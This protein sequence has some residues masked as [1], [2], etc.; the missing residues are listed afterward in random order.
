M[1]HIQEI[2]TKFIKSLKD[3][4]TKPTQVNADAV[5]ITSYALIKVILDNE[6]TIYKYLTN[7]LNLNEQ[8]YNIFIENIRNTPI[9]ELFTYSLEQNLHVLYLANYMYVI[10]NSENKQYDNIF[11]TIEEYKI[12]ELEIASYLRYHKIHCNPLLLYIFLIYASE[13]LDIELNF[14]E[15]YGHDSPLFDYIIESGIIHNTLEAKQSIN[16]LLMQ[17]VPDGTNFNDVLSGDAL[18]RKDDGIRRTNFDYHG[19]LGTKLYKVPENKILVIITPFNRVSSSIYT[20]LEKNILQQIFKKSNIVK[21]INNYTCY[22]DFVV[23]ADGLKDCVLYG[24]QVYYPGQPYYDINL[25][26]STKDKEDFSFMGT[27]TYTQNMSGSGPELNVEHNKKLVNTSI[28]GLIAGYN[29]DIH[30]Y[31]DDLELIFVTSCRTFNQG[32][33]S[34]YA[35]EMMYRY[36]KIHNLLNDIISQCD[37]QIEPIFMHS[38][39]TT[40]AYEMGDMYRK[41]DESKIKNDAEKLSLMFN[42]RLSPMRK[43]EFLINNSSTPGNK[44]R[45]K[46]NDRILSFLLSA[47]DHEKINRLYG[48]VFQLLNENPSYLS[49]IYDNMKKLL[50][51][52]LEHILTDYKNLLNLLNYIVITHNFNNLYMKLENTA[53]EVYPVSIIFTVYL[54]FIKN[55]DIHNPTINTLVLDTLSYMFNL[56]NIQLKSKMT[57][58]AQLIQKNT[59]SNSMNYKVLYELQ[60]HIY[61]CFD[62]LLTWFNI[63]NNTYGFNLQARQIY[64]LFYNFTTLIWNEYSP[65]FVVISI[66]Q[67]YEKHRNIIDNHMFLNIFN[68]LIIIHEGM[69]TEEKD[70]FILH[71]KIMLLLFNNIYKPTKVNINTY[72]KPNTTQK[73]SAVKRKAS[74]L[75][76]ST[77]NTINTKKSK[78]N[79][80]SIYIFNIFNIVNFV[81]SKFNNSKIDLATIIRK[82]LNYINDVKK[83]D[84]SL[85]TL[86]DKIKTTYIKLVD[87][88]VHGFSEY[89][90]EPITVDINPYQNPI[91]ITETPMYDAATPMDEINTPNQALSPTFSASLQ[92]NY[93]ADTPMPLGEEGEEREEMELN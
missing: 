39:V 27:Y 19:N 83:N 6:A 9:H 57:D 87:S 71:A 16:D 24:M 42:K 21:F 88:I 12:T 15:E 2:A 77:T 49:H 26:V 5:S 37:I 40:C 28:A 86:L 14:R 35:I 59:N 90:P 10:N 51:L 61:D 78:S 65:F 56:F 55:I 41:I 22:I 48:D 84:R 20:K 72:K 25:E 46:Y 91:Q 85:I 52:E 73:S 58:I 38:T 7:Y 23:T 13:G 60:Q 70:I 18:Q 33:I 3:T 45:Y 74:N 67:L 32:R 54:L 93:E 62:V 44:K 1:D 34:N 81:N 82:I 29:P 69:D 43:R 76:K 75:I 30:P 50:E 36:N 92:Y 4:F 68:S 31:N 64:A 53:E 79:N 17:R 11:T 89:E 63:Y 80:S 8:T 66:F 47:S